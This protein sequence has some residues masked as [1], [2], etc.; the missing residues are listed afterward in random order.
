[1]RYWLRY[2]A[3]V[4]LNLVRPHSTLTTHLNSH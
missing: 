3:I 2:L 4:A 1:M